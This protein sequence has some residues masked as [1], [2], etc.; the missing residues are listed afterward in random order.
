MERYEKL[1]EEY[2]EAMERWNAPPTEE[3]TQQEEGGGVAP[4][5]VGVAQTGEGVVM[6]TASV[7]L[8]TP[9]K[10]T[11]EPAIQEEQSV[12]ESTVGNKRARTEVTADEKEATPTKRAKREAEKVAAAAPTAAE[13]GS[14]GESRTAAVAQQKAVKPT[15]EHVPYNATRGLK[16]S[17]YCANDGCTQLAVFAEGRGNGY[18]SN[19]C[20]VGHCR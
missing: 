15:I 13:I 19:E 1:K 14:P 3:T 6:G 5:P 9:S 16:D 17:K 8:S 2:K 4:S 10:Q 12:E 11:A 7:L 20:V 18:C